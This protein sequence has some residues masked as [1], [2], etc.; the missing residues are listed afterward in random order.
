MCT[1]EDALAP[2]HVRAVHD[3]PAIEPA[4]PE[5]RGIEHVGTVRGRDEDDPFVRLEPVH[6]DEQLVQRLLALVVTAAEA[7]AAMTA[8]RID[9]VDEHDARSVLLALLEQV[10]HARRADADEHLDEVRSAD[11]EERHVRF[12][13]DGAREQ[14]L[15]GSRR[16]HQQD[17][18]RNAAAELLKLLRFLEELD[19]FLQLFLRFVD[20]RD[21]LERHFLLRARR[22]L[23]LALA[24]REGL[25]AA[26]LHLAH[27]ENPETNQQQDGSPGIQQLCPRALRRLFGRHENAL[28]E[29]LIRQTF[30]LSGGVGV[31]GFLVGSVDAADF[32]AGDGDPFDLLGSPHPP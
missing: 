1:T 13:R 26:A 4:G 6:L 28:R 12:A 15:A 21:V 19:D 18:F 20:A 11:R 22:K 9:L 3:D 31:E 27:E 10:A 16:A 14:R 17:A 2:L 23:R 25:V 5:Q 29:Q 8:D 7:R 24:E 30:V 32:L